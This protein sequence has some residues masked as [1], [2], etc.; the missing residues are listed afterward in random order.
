[1]RWGLRFKL[2]LFLTLP[3]LVASG[4]ALVL[5][6]R[7]VS[8]YQRTQT[9]ARLHDQGPGVARIFAEKAVKFLTDSRPGEINLSNEIRTVVNADVY[10]VSNPAADFAYPGGNVARWPRLKLDWRRINRGEAIVVDATP[11]G[12]KQK[13]VVVAS[14]IFLGNGN[15]P[16]PN[17]DQDAIGAIALARPVSSLGPSNGFWA[18]RL[19]GATLI[20]VGLAVLLGLLFGLR[21]AQP[22]RRLVAATRAIAQGSYDVSLDRRRRDEIGQLN[23]AFGT[24]ARQLAQAREHERQFLMRVSHELRTPLTAI[25][26]HV[27][28]LADGIIEE[29]DER[30][31]AYEVMGGEI[32]RLE[33][34]IRDLLDLAR[35]EA[36][37]FPLRREE[38]D[39]GALVE[40][41]RLANMQAA[42]DADVHLEA[43]IVD[44]G[45][46]IGDGDRILQIVGN[47]VDNAIRWTPAGGLVELTAE[48]H[49]NQF[50][51]RVRDTGPG[52]PRERRTEIFRPF[53]TGNDHGT[54]LGLAIA[55]ELAAAMGGRIT[56]DDPPGGG[57]RFTVTL[58]CVAAQPMGALAPAR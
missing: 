13:D 31:T 10:F 34:L 35:L 4:I 3:V 43:E 15:R 33:R 20:G 39:V 24:M 29:E 2:V 12:S 30:Q 47:L 32:G 22:L 49:G 41:C 23:R 9:V 46:V 28:A 16:S 50:L 53:H 18:R 5:G 1:M 11:P 27:A 7:T 44:A 37:R 17:G 45:V 36:R 42:R 6:A 51:I 19:L 56:L 58:P 54:G 21:L 55:A 40:A 8:A 38:V 26:G 25:R 57:A 52:I 14:G 48:R